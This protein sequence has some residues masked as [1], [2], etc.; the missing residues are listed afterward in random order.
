MYINLSLEHDVLIFNRVMNI[1]S[2]MFIVLCSFSSTGTFSYDESCQLYKPFL[3]I[4]VNFSIKSKTKTC[5]LKALKF[6][7]Q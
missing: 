4:I 1:S 7:N 3:T 2:S 5:R 6:T